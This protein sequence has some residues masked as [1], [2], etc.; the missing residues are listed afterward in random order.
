V[1]IN[2]SKQWHDLEE[3]KMKKE[4][5]KLNISQYC[6][7]Q[8]VEARCSL[9]F[10]VGG[11]M[12]ILITCALLSIYR[13]GC[14]KMR[15]VEQIFISDPYPGFH[16]IVDTPINF[17]FLLQ[18]RI[19]HQTLT[20]HITSTFDPLYVISVKYRLSLPEDGSYVIWNMLE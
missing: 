14:N 5:L 2:K 3:Y 8:W 16:Y 6:K 12:F 13:C 19:C 17:S 15:I 1:T 11:I 18:S 7:P 4:N 9:I 10:I 20:T